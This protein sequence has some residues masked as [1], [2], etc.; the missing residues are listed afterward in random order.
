MAQVSYTTYRFRAP[1]LMDE[2]FFDYLKGLP[3]KEGSIRYHPYEGFTKTFP[4]WCIFFVILVLLSAWLH[5]FGEGEIRMT[6]LLIPFT[7]W[8]MFA[9]LSGAL[10]SMFSWFGYYMDCRAYFDT[11]SSHI[12]Q[13]KSYAELERLRNGLHVQPEDALQALFPDWNHRSRGNPRQPWEPR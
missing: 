12:N 3:V 9:T 6:G 1:P 10:F 11:Y 5:F 2:A 13:A 7:I 8:P 4:G